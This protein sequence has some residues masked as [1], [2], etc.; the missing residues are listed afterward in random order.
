M[1]D[2]QLTTPRCIRL[3]LNFTENVGGTVVTVRTACM[4]IHVT[5]RFYYNRDNCYLV[6]SLRTSR[7]CSLIR[8]CRRASDNDRYQELFE[9][10]FKRELSWDTGHVLCC[11]FFSI[12]MLPAMSPFVSEKE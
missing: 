7:R 3:N 1:L 4:L 6:I 12:T 2:P 11:N 8:V 9:A 5:C 10:T